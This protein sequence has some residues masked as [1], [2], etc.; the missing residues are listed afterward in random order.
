MSKS[1]YFDLTPAETQAKVKGYIYNRD[2]LASNFR[3]LFT[4]GYNQYAAKG[5]NKTAKEL[6]PIDSIDN[7]VRQPRNNDDLYERNKKI[8]EANK[9]YFK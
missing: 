5:K 7:Q 3:A 2:V 9:Q 6:W 1:E 4:L 8:V